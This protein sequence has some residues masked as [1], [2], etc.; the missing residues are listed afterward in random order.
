MGAASADGHRHFNLDRHAE[1]KG[2][3][4]N[5]AT[6]VLTLLAENLDEQVRCTI[7][8]FRLSFEFWCAVDHAVDAHD[9]FDTI[10]V[11]YLRLQRCEGRKYSCFRCKISRLDVNLTAKPALVQLLGTIEGAVSRDEHEIAF[12]TGADICANGLSRG[13]KDEPE[14]FEAS[15]RII[16]SHFVLRPQNGSCYL[17]MALRCG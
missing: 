3:E 12:L 16:V 7:D 2:T 8:D 10:E 5:R 17:R 11:A 4:S 13:R 6:R 15:F 9:T 14:F 1:G